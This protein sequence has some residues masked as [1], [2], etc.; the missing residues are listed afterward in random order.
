FD[1][2]ITACAATNCVE[3][4]IPIREAGKML[5]DGVL[6]QNTSNMGPIASW[7]L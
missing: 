6:L 7:Y 2:Y 5:T 4:P 3:D 1:P